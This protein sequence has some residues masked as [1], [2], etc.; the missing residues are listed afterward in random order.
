MNIF[1]SWTILQVLSPIRSQR[2]QLVQMVS[3]SIQEIWESI[4]SNSDAAGTAGYWTAA[5]HRMRLQDLSGW[6]TYAS[7]HRKSATETQSHGTTVTASQAAEFIIGLL[8]AAH[9]NPS[10]GASQTLLFLLDERHVHIRAAVVHEVQASSFTSGVA[11]SVC[12]MR[13]CVSGSAY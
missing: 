1:V 2:L 8:F 9:K 5:L 4:E 10:L 3:E 6:D 12:S 11:L 7:K 13:T